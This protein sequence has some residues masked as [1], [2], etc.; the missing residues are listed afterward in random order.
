[1]NSWNYLGTNVE[2]L[3][4]AFVWLLKA[5]C[6]TNWLKFSSIDINI[7]AH[8]VQ[9]KS[10]PGLLRHDHAILVRWLSSDA[11]S[12]TNSRECKYRFLSVIWMFLRSLPNV[13]SFLYISC[14]IDLS[15]FLFYVST[16]HSQKHISF[17]FKFYFSSIFGKDM[18]LQVRRN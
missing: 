2:K 10:V 1:M 15:I 18:L 17:E 4:F 14:S 9:L 8:N 16:C 6:C 11:I 3:K 12:F 13:G 5:P 7:L